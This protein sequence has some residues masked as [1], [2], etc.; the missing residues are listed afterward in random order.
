MASPGGVQELLACQI[1][2]WYPAFARVTFKTV[3]LPLPAAVAD[4]LVADGLHLAPDSQAVSAERPPCNARIHACSARLTPTGR[5][6]RCRRRCRSAD[7]RAPSPLHCLQFAKRGP[8]EE[9]PDEDDYQDWQWEDGSGGGSGGSEA[10]AAAQVRAAWRG[11]PTACV[12]QAHTCANQ[13]PTRPCFLPYCCPS[14]SR[15]QLSWTS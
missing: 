6:P 5:P 12:Q 14:C 3:V 4:W 8:L 13:V 15:R 9:Y 10:A 7:T 2:A 1:S 11:A